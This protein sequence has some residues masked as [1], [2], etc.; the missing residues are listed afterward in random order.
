MNK[1]VDELD[2][3]N[4]CHNHPLSRPNVNIVSRIGII[5]IAELGMYVIT[6][7]AHQLVGLS[8]RFC[9]DVVNIFAILLFGKHL[10]KMAVWLYQ[11]YASDETR[12][13]CHCMPSCSEYAL[14]AL[15]KYFWPKA[16]W[17]IYRRLTYTC[18]L[19]GYKVDYP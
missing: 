10:C 16:L 14:L 19:P 7:P 18:C 17:K 8:Q 11:K 1:I 2:I 4:Y 6:F 9:L 13:K 3:R 15:D 12:R 5:V